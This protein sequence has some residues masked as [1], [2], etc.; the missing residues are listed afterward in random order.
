VSDVFVMIELQLAASPG[1][2]ALSLQESEIAEARW[3][4]LDELQALEYYRPGGMLY[5]MV[6]GPKSEGQSGFSAKEMKSANRPGSA[7]V[8]R[9][10]L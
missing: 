1:A 9:A 10:R 6:L 8:Y 4:P 2:D 5:E 3:M 7:H